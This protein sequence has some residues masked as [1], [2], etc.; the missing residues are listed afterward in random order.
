MKYVALVAAKGT[1][2]RVK[3]KNIRPFGDTNLVEL[4]LNQLK[5]VSGLDRIVVSSE[6][7]RI[8]ELAK[9]MDVDIHIRDPKYSTNSIPMSS[10]YSYLASDISGDVI[11]WIQVNNPLIQPSSYED[12]IYVHKNLSNEYNCLLSVS[13]INKYLFYKGNPINFT[14][15]PWMKSQDLK[16]LCELNFG[17]CILKREDM[18]QWGSLVGTKPYFF[19]GN[20]E[21]FTDIDDLTAFDFCEMIYNKN[22]NKVLGI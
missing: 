4:K 22:K 8:L 16:D 19:C 18:K 12:A 9:S 7:R 17:I 6:D 11:V 5:K 10:V 21:E 2:E 20:A 13:K 1:S 3:N 14:I 15:N